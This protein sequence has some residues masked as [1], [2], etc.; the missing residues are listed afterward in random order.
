MTRHDR[1]P[2]IDIRRTVALS[3]G[4]NGG[5]G[6]NRGAVTP[7]SAVAGFCGELNRKC[8]VLRRGQGRQI[9]CPVSVLAVSGWMVGAY[10]MNADIL[11]RKYLQASC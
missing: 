5:R 2:V 10:L 7:V 6:K 4:G 3:P 1:R 8:G 11:M 9:C